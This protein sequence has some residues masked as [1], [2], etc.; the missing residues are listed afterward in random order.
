MEIQDSY[1]SPKS[2]KKLADFV[3]AIENDETVVKKIEAIRADVEALAL[4]FPMPGMPAGGT[5]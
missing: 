2:S 4:K 5:F 1:V 3:H